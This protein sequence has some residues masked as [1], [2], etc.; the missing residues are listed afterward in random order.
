MMR[1]RTTP[2]TVPLWYNNEVT[3]GPEWLIK[4]LWERTSEH[5]GRKKDSNK[6]K[7]YRVFCLK[8]APLIVDGCP[9]LSASG[10]ISGLFAISFLHAQTP[11]PKIPSNPR[12][13]EKKNRHLIGCTAWSHG[14]EMRARPPRSPMGPEYVIILLRCDPCSRSS[15]QIATLYGRLYAYPC[16]DH[17]LSEKRPRS[18]DPR[19]RSRLGPLRGVERSFP[20]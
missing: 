2:G 12:T 3:T 9:P 20:P 15:H 7:S 8:A 13:E 16:T 11:S 14:P 5:E 17:P 18:L 19:V 4:N 6:N 10:P 1:P